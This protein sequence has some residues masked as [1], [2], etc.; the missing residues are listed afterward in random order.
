MKFSELYRL[1]EDDGW[2]IKSTNKHIKYVHASNQG[3]FLWANTEVRKYRR[4]H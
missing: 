1:L 4:V 3:L 2:Y